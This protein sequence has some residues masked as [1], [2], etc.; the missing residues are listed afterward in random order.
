MSTD[1]LTKTP[2]ENPGPTA[3]P[4]SGAPLTARR[5]VP[6]WR[7]RL[8]GGRIALRL[9]QRPLVTGFA[10]LAA[11]LTVSVLA[12]GTGDF[13]VSPPDVVR[14]LTGAGTTATD[15]VVNTLRLPRLLVGI[16]V[17]AALGMSGAVFQSL[18]RNPLGSPDIIGFETGAA[19]GALLQL[20]IFGGGPFAVAVSAVLGGLGTALAVYALSYK[21]GVQG[22]RLILVGIAAGA[23]L[24]SVNSYLMIKASLDEAQAAAVWLTGS[25]NGRGWDQLAPALIAVAVLVPAVL[26]LGPHLRMMEAGDASAKSLGVPVERSRLA[27]VVLAVLL[28][29]TATAAAGPIAF[30]ALA[31]PQ[32]ARRLTRSAGVTLVP[33]ALMGALLLIAGDFA[34]QRVMAPIQ[35][36]VGIMTAAI[37]G[38]YLMWLLTHEWRAGRR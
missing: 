28:C 8:A 38:L 27:L 30:V 13:T 6:G 17:G 25:L 16:V 20:L 34:A 26:L 3:P 11:V 5:L 19:T 9:P 15:Y 21:R 24:S 23:L 10:L 35:L 37:G 31:A 22:Y 18:A 32:L 1:S 36:P 33:A 29:A 14:A 2:V 7:L 12:L 4:P